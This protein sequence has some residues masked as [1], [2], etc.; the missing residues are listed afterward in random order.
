MPLFYAEKH[1]QDGDYNRKREQSQKCGEYVEDY[2]EREVLFIRRDE[3]L[4]NLEKFFHINTFL[5]K[6]KPLQRDN[7]SGYYGPWQII[8]LQN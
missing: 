6:P 8:L 4:D 3:A 7:K 5:C 1:L 2:V